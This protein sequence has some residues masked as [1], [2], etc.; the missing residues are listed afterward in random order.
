MVPRRPCPRSLRLPRAIQT[1]ASQ[2]GCVQ[3]PRAAHST[4]PEIFQNKNKR[5][6]SED[7]N[8]R[9]VVQRR[10][11]FPTSEYGHAGAPLLSANALSKNDVTFKRFNLGTRSKQRRKAAEKYLASIGQGD[12]REEH[13]TGR[14]EDG[15]CLDGA[16]GN[17]SSFDTLGGGLD[18]SLYTDEEHPVW[19]RSVDLTGGDGNV[20][21]PVFGRGIVERLLQAQRRDENAK[22]AAEEAREDQ[23]RGDD[24]VGVEEGRRQRRSVH[25]EQERIEEPT[26]D[27]QERGHAYWKKVEGKP[28]DGKSLSSRSMAS[29]EHIVGGQAP[30][31]KQTTDPSARDAL[32]NCRKEDQSAAN[33]RR[34]GRRGRHTLAVADPAHQNAEE[35]MIGASEME[36]EH[37]DSDPSI[38]PLGVVLEPYAAGSA[39]DVPVS[40]RKETNPAVQRRYTLERPGDSKDH[41]R[42][43]SRGAHSDPDGERILQFRKQYTSRLIS[44][45]RLSDSRQRELEQSPKYKKGQAIES[46]IAMLE[47]MERRRHSTQPFRQVETNYQ[48]QAHWRLEQEAQWLDVAGLLD[49]VDETLLDMRHRRERRPSARQQNRA[50]ATNADALADEGIPTAFDPAVHDT[51]SLSGHARGFA[52]MPDAKRQELEQKNK[53]NA[54]NSAEEHDAVKDEAE[55]HYE[56]L[57]ATGGESKADS[58]PQDT[59]KPKKTIADMDRELQQK[60]AGH[61]GDGGEAGVEY[62]NGEPVAMK[63]SVKNNMFRYI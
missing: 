7:P 42:P 40:A 22:A 15:R 11:K 33:A 19:H 27:G 50:S 39:T 62:E 51:A 28:E 14:I 9:D 41:T 61:T 43:S 55:K 46:H 8:E 12:A 29:V 32:I 45:F 54:E 52:T 16:Q 36:T 26:L 35:E 63:R 49:R 1:S 13:A 57:T 25:D 21:G 59:Q 24:E 6:N 10:I 60:M 37:S 47:A 38:L 4:L 17:A 56:H 53:A 58:G 48:S 23:E 2:H 18:E 34:A 31:V 3:P 5:R 30:H 20:L 44:R